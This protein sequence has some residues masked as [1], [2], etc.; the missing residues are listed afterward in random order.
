VEGAP[1]TLLFESMRSICSD[2]LSFTGALFVAP[3]S[4]PGFVRLG[5]AAKPAFVPISSGVSSIHSA[6]ACVEL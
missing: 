4:K 2:V 1:I 6:V 3:R 5:N